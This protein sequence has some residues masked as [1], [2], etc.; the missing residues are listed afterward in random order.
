MLHPADRGVST[1]NTH[2]HT[3][4]SERS[5]AHIL[6]KGTRIASNAFPPLLMH[7]PDRAVST[8]DKLIPHLF[9]GSRKV[10][11]A[12]PS[13]TPHPLDKAAST[14]NTHI[15]TLV[16]EDSH[17]HIL[18]KRTGLAPNTSPPPMQHSLHR[19]PST[20]N[21][22]I[23]TLVFRGKGK[24]YTHS[25]SHTASS[26]SSRINHEHMPRDNN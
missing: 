22:R 18:F 5:H 19:I 9:L 6:F 25:C 24:I 26:R 1:L 3:L 16:S 23:P 7:P 2:V 13:P 11:H 20:L 8:L 10:L 4:I 17:P 12:F 15:H 21:A 14:L